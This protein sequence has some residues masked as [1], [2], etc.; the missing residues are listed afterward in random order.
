[1]SNDRINELPICA[2]ASQVSPQDFARSFGLNIRTPEQKLAEWN[3]GV[4]RYVELILSG[5]ECSS[6]GNPQVIEAKRRIAE[7]GQLTE[8]A[9]DPLPHLEPKRRAA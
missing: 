7:G 4:E 1:M 2:D 8:V 6:Y 5:C 3:A 9:S